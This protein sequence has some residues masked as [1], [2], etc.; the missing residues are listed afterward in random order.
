MCSGE[1]VLSV[2]F[3]EANST[4][5]VPP[6]PFRLPCWITSCFTKKKEKAFDLIV[7]SIV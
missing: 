5:T 2:S 7:K 1:N 6:S 3:E 4:S